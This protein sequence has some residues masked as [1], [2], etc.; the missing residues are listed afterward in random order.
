[1]PATSKLLT[2]LVILAV[3]SL[4][5]VV[6]FIR[7]FSGTKIRG[8]IINSGATLANC[9]SLSGWLSLGASNLTD[10]GTFTSV[11]ASNLTDGGTFTS[12]PLN[13]EH[14][15]NVSQPS[16]RTH[17]IKS[18]LLRNVLITN[19]SQSVINT[20]SSKVNVQRQ[21]ATSNV[22][23]S[24]P[25][26]ASPDIPIN[27]VN[28]HDKLC[29]EYLSKRDH[30]LFQ[31]CRLLSRPSNEIDANPN[32]HFMDGAG[33]DPVGLVSVPGS[34]NTWV[35]GL[36][37][38]A[39]GICTGSIY[40]DQ[41]LRQRGFMGEYVQSGSV[42]VVKTHT[43]DYQWKG[44]PV[45]VRNNEDALY[46]SAILLIRNPYDTFVSEHNRLE[47]LKRLGSNTIGIPPLGRVDNSHVHTIGE[48][49]FGE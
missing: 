9:N 32:C 25:I 21:P 4:T 28:C 36:L 24:P 20:I 12:T 1:M 31:R 35:R 46:G 17:T 11:G 10:G 5:S 48:E 3:V 13:L 40:C 14:P 19:G 18:S 33:R 39:T 42:L 16:I 8:Y 41:P 2:A 23:H 27:G 29:S 34:G 26:L 22:T 43:S 7:S 30:A 6:C 44:T 37:E 49:Y 38:R 47:T 45:A 15:M